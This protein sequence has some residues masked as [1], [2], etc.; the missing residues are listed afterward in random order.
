MTERLTFQRKHATGQIVNL[1]CGDDPVGFGDR[2][3]HVDVDEWNLP[4]FVLAEI[5][6]LPFLAKSFDTAVLGDVLEHCLDPEGAVKEAARIAK[7]LVLTI[8]EELALPSVGTHVE[9]GLRQR[10]DHYRRLFGLVGTDE[11]VIVAHKRSTATFVSS[12]TSESVVPHDGHINRFDD[13]WVARLIE[14]SAMRVVFFEKSGGYWFA[15]L[16]D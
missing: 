6:D 2:A 7:R 10:A 4:N 12:P 14:T 1:G 5:H 15:L 13:A 3:T 8:P 9:L 11:E 16:E